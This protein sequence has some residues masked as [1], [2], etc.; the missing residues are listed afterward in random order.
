MEKDRRDS[1]I[2]RNNSS[3]MIALKRKYNATLD[4]RDK[5]VSN[6]KDYDE[7]FGPVVIA[8]KSFPDI[9]SLKNKI[10]LVIF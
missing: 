9:R 5:A 1:F 4:R 10:K 8:G 7:M 6:V 3:I 2:E